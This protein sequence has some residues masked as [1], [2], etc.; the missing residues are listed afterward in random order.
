M[1]W[2]E[3]TAKAKALREEGVCSVQGAERSRKQPQR[4]KGEGNK[5]GHTGRSSGELGLAGQAEEPD[6]TLRARGSHW[7][8]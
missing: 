5:C 6:F 8:V 3:L 1:F 4:S 7:S 2:A